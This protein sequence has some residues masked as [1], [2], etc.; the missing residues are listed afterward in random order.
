MVAYS[1]AWA[2]G[3]TLFLEDPTLNVSATPYVLSDH[4]RDKIAISYDTQALSQRMAQGQMRRF[5]TS[6]KRKIITDWKD[7]PSAGGINF[8][9]DGNPGGAFLKSFYEQNM[10]YPV[11]VQAN[12]STENWYASNNTNTFTASSNSNLYSNTNPSTIGSTTNPTFSSTFQ[13][14]GVNSQSFKISSASISTVTNGTGSL[15]FYT[16]VPHGFTGG[17]VLVTGIGQPYNGNW[18]IASVGTNSVTVAFN[19]NL[20]FNINSYAISGS[21]A[22]F[23]LD[24]TDFLS[25]GEVLTIA[26]TQNVSAITYPNINGYWQ[27]L[28]TS[29]NI[30]TAASVTSGTPNNFAYSYSD[31]SFGFIGNATVF[32]S[33][34][35]FYKTLTQLIPSIISGAG[36][37]EVFKTYITNFTYDVT[38]RYALTDLVDISIEFTEI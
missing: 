29:G 5:I 26:G 14:K 6:N 13:N 24:N 7:L 34:N 16:S 9:A 4:N 35:P 36:Y 11:W 19:N 1:P 27:V 18:N 38:R 12:Y 3:L 17:A 15:V 23:N 25:V 37:S 33:A 2:S 8:T 20:K 10:F 30:M 22:Q 32:Y 28:S 21:V 31:T